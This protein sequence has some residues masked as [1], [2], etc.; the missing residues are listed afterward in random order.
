MKYARYIY[1]K[2][3]TT[4]RN[5]DTSICNVNKDFNYIYHRL[6]HTYL[7]NYQKQFIMIY[8]ADSKLHYSI[9][10]WYYKQELSSVNL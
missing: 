7:I 6:Q 10:L 5:V 8:K 2:I 3:R 4:E 9:W 1:H